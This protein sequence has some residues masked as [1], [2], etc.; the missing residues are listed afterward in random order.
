MFGATNLDG[1]DTLSGVS[2]GNGFH[3]KIRPFSETAISEKILYSAYHTAGALAYRAKTSRSV[4]IIIH[5][6]T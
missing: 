2:F 3:A 5:T 1:R 4:L 6:K